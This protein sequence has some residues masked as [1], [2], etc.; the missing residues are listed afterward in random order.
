[1]N[2]RDDMS[3][4]IDNLRIAS[5]KALAPPA[6]IADE[7]PT[8]PEATQT[9]A[10]ARLEAS[11][12]I[13]GQDDRLLVVVGPCSIHDPKAALEYAAWLQDMRTQYQDTLQLIMQP[14]CIF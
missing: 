13:Q 8:K 3:V 12:I 11:R 4:S 10:T 2:L 14:S 1:M 7:L 5:L 9:I 6:L